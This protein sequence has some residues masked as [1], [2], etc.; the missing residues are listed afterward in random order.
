MKITSKKVRMHCPGRGRLAVYIVAG[1]MVSVLTSNGAFACEVTT[2]HLHAEGEDAVCCCDAPTFRVEWWA[3]EGGDGGDNDF[4]IELY[5]ETASGWILCLSKR[6]ADDDVNDDPQVEIIGCGTCCHTTVPECCACYGM[7]FKV[8]VRRVGVG[9]WVWSNTVE[10]SLYCLDRIDLQCGNIWED[11][12]GETIYVLRGTRYNFKAVACGGPGLPWPTGHPVWWRD[13]DLLEDEIGKEIT[14][15]DFDDTGTVTL[16]AACGGDPCPN[17][18]T[19]VVMQPSLKQFGW[20]GD[21]NLY[22]TPTGWDGWADGNSAITDPT[23]V[24]STKDEPACVTKNSSSVSLDKCEL[25]WSNGL[26]CATKIEVRGSGTE[27]WGPDDVLISDSNTETGEFSVDISGSMIDQVH[28]YNGNFFIDWDYRQKSRGGTWFPITVLDE[29]HTVYVTYGTPSPPVPAD[30]TVKR[31]DQLCQWAHG[32]NTL[33]G[34]ADAIHT[35]LSLPFGDSPLSDDWDLMCGP[36]PAV[37]K[38]DEHARFF[39]RCLDLIGVS[40][41]EKYDTYASED[42]EVYNDKDSKVV[43]SNTYWLKFDENG[44]GTVDNN[45]VGS[46]KVPTGSAITAVHYYS[47]TPKLNASSDCLLWRQIGPDNQDW[48]QKW[49]YSPDGSWEAAWPPQPTLPGN[50]PY[51][52]CP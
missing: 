45:S 40:G 41:S 33:K 37:G 44:D 35:N 36:C 49:I 7:T 31:I 2:V 26:S 1:A 17:T 25:D 27:D 24:R 50:E 3:R 16:A 18:V 30:L 22:E 12:S 5:M 13:G 11:V 32:Q 28:R 47:V 9:D 43:D 34:V 15:Q 4:E 21:H 10:F 52:S 46:V 20:S 14:T 19:I 8:R 38:S 23:Y 48:K 51:D 39:V 29:Y 6:V 42:T